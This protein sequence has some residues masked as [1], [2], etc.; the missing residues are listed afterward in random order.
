[1]S[2]GP[3]RATV[4]CLIEPGAL[5]GVL[6]DS[7][8]RE[9]RRDLVLRVVAAW[10]DTVPERDLSLHYAKA[11][12]GLGPDDLRELAESV[13]AQGSAVAVPNGEFLVRSF[14]SLGRARRE[15]LAAAAGAR[16]VAA[17]D[18]GVTETQMIATVL[19]CLS[20]AR[21]EELAHDCTEL[22]LRDWLGS[23][24]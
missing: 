4:P 18:A 15:A 12:E 11:V 8:G 23:P 16:A 17:F 7:L 10:V 6:A 2:L 14:S 1:M 21:L 13:G 24:H 19:P 20:R 22:Y 3:D 9:A 5:V